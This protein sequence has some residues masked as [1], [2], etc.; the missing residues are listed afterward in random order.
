[1]GDGEW[2]VIETFSD[3]PTVVA[4]GS[5]ARNW[6]P[7]SNV[8]RG[9]SLAMVQK[10]VGVVVDNLK[11]S[12]T[13]VDLT[14]GTRLAYARPILGP[15]R[16]VHAVMV[17]LGGRDENPPPPPRALGWTWDVTDP[18]R[19]RP[20]CH[21]G[22]GEFYGLP[23][24]GEPSLTDLLSTLTQLP[25]LAEILEAID[26][27]APDRAGTGEWTMRRPDGRTMKVRYAFRCAQTD[28]RLLLHGISQELADDDSGPAGRLAAEVLHQVAVDRHPALVHTDSGHVRAWLTTAPDFLPPEVVRGLSPLPAGSLTAV[29][30]LPVSTALRMVSAPASH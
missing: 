9:S 4:A 24:L 10:L 21:P 6:R 19:P 16:Q 1:M 27:A 3:A 20:V 17:W 11:D 26:T 14:P 30:G 29:P 28:G 22:C 25:E 13:L 18:G 15:G 23:D 5:R 12:Q 7:L 2:L 8:F